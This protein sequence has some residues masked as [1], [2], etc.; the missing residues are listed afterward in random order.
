[1]SLI[2]SASVVF[3]ADKDVKRTVIKAFFSKCRCVWQ[4][5]YFW[6]IFSVMTDKNTEHSRL[7]DVHRHSN[8]PE[9]NEFVDAFWKAHLAPYFKEKPTGRKPKAKPKAQFKVM[10]L[11]LYVAWL[12]DPELCISIARGD[13]N[14]DADS[15]YNKLHISK[16]IKRVSD[17]LLEQGFI[18]QKIGTEGNNRVT[19]IWP[20][21]PL[22]AYFRTAAFSEFHID[23][24]EDKECIVL[25]DKV[26]ERDADAKEIASS[27][28]LEY[29][30]EDVP[31]DV[32]TAREC[33]KSYNTLLRLS[34]VDIASQ[35]STLVT[36]DHFN[37]KRKR[38]EKRRVSL[39]HDN[40]FVR[41]IFYRG[42]WSLG[43]RYH[44]GWWQQVPS[45]L[46]KDILIND[47]HT[48]E[49][50]YS[51]FHVSIAYG[52]EGLQPPDDPYILNTLV[53]PLKPKQQR[54][55]VKLL[56]LTAINAKDSKSA[57]NAFRDERNREQRHLPEDQKISYRNEMLKLLLDQFVE[58]NK[59]I[60]HYLC[61]DKGVELMAID[62]RI[63]ARIIEHF[64]R[65][66][67]PVLTVHDSYVIQSQYEQELVDQMV[68]ATKAEIGDFH[69]KKKQEKLSPNVVTE[70]T[71]M[72]NQINVLDGYQ[73]I[74]DS[75]V[76]TEGYKL[77]YERFARYLN[78]YH[79]DG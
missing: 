10:F 23:V 74:A 79:P 69:F 60:E 49:V 20:L 43:G 66:K 1:M 53:E 72:D 64:T 30:D 68:Y 37:R 52:L 61:T 46:R 21:N 22:I 50:D 73:S 27:V 48:V 8:Y 59:P 44:G 3:S 13:K 2:G 38:Y 39:R 24:H 67:I 55:D 70:F 35:D 15:R 11:D 26:I 16:I 42:D 36:S 76:R 12:E 28:E 65:K 41:R 17:A 7:L 31:F 40:K 5:R 34:Q 9:V 25:K 58:E 14:F 57:F 45:E 56:V 47:Q 54:Q 18:D 6:G 51:G 75:I 62:G 4:R 77:R 33:L 63:T 71:R 78:D 29:R 19:R 32:H